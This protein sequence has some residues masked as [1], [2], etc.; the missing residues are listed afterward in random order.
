M[1]LARIEQLLMSLQNIYIQIFNMNLSLV[2]RTLK[3]VQFITTDFV[4]C[5]NLSL[6]FVIDV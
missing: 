2:E 3:V 5:N 6:N 1:S 4:S